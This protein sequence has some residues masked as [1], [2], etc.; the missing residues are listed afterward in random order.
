MFCRSWD[1]WLLADAALR[2]F[3]GGP[4]MLMTGIITA[5]GAFL[6]AFLS[7]LGMIFVEYQRKPKLHFKIEYPPLD[8]TYASAQAKEAR[9]LRVELSNNAMPRLLKWLGRDAAMHCEGNI[10]FHH[11]E[12][13]IPV[14]SKSMPIRWAGSD[15]PVT[16]QLM[17]N[18]EVKLLFDPAKYNAAF[19]RNCFPGT[20]ELIDVAA[21]FDNDDQCYGWSND[22]YLVPFQETL[23]RF[24]RAWR[25]RYEAYRFSSRAIWAWPV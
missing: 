17:P 8:C 16:P 7:F 15:E 18:E 4:A 22:N 1:G 19:H 9:F 21:R 5:I 24:F 12:N 23:C 13:G 20:K 14:F 6:G 3:E 11:F 2:H 10:Q 25:L